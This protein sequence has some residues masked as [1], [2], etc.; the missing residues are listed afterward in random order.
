MVS[1]SV[2]FQCPECA[3]QGAK[4]QRLVDVARRQSTP[5][6]TY[7]LIGV[8]V[9][10]FLVGLVADRQLGGQ[11]GSLAGRFGEFGPAIRNGEWWR[12]VTGGFLHANL[13]HVGM[14]MYVLYLMGTVLEPAIGRLRF[15]LIYA[16]SLFGGSLGALILTPNGLTVGASGAIFGLFAAL[17]CVQ[18]SRGQNPM[19]GGIGSTIAINLVIT[20]VFSQYISVGGHVGG[21][22]AGAACG[23]LLFGL[24]PNQARQRQKSEAVFTA[25]VG[26]LGVGLLAA[27]VVLGQTLPAALT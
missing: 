21:L 13:L 27:A 2:G 1:A 17:A 8:N 16:V 15:G 9:A 20:L 11:W 22:I 26:V 10:V 5:H 4:Q 19:Q 12:L 24:S 23:A 18:L 6:L 14:N 3:K 7:A 25:A